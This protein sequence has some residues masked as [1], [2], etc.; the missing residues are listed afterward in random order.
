M[1]EKIEAK[2]SNVRSLLEKLRANLNEGRVR[3]NNNQKDWQYY[4]SLVH[5]EKKLEELLEFF[6]TTN[7]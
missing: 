1:K 2:E 7:K 6:E 4:P 5:T 3:Y